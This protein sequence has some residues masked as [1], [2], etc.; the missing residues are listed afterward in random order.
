M[1]FTID[2]FKMDIYFLFL[3]EEQT[4]KPAKPLLTWG[5]PIAYMVLYKDIL[6]F[7]T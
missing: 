6:S 3:L 7:A 5:I 2:I 1:L 4:S